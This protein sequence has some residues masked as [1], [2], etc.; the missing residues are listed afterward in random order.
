MIEGAQFP[1]VAFSTSS[2]D[3]ARSHADRK[4]MMGIERLV[5]VSDSKQS[6]MKHLPSIAGH[7]ILEVFN[8]TEIAFLFS[9]LGG[10]TGSLGTKLFSSVANARGTL[11]IVLVAMP[12]SAESIRRRETASRTLSE[13]IGVSSLCIVFD[14]DK[15]STL[16][17]NLAIS[18]AFGLMNGIMMRPV[19]DLCV[20]TSRTDLP[21]VRQVL[22]GSNYGRF[23]LGL[24]RGDDRV[25]RAVGESLSSPWFDFPMES[26]DAAV[27][28][29]SAAD[30]WEKEA[31][32]ILAVL[33][34]RIPQARL[35]WGIYADQSLGDRIR[36]SLVLCKKK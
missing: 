23:G 5:G 22:S 17:P 1:T 14:N 36:L 30:P 26:V 9:G 34:A 28:V 21:S 35:L 29:Y 3:L 19:M 12:F 27:A 11:D 24:A 10:M 16:A 31:E 18:R 4:L 8:N 33:E 6:V 25:E 20:A 32:K 2:A 13:V 7:E 15:L